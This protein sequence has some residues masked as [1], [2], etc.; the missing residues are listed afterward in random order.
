VALEKAHKGFVE[1]SHLPGPV[2]GPAA[3]VL[4]AHSG[5][6]SQGQ[7]RVSI[8]N[9][10]SF[11]GLPQDRYAHRHPYPNVRERWRRLAFAAGPESVEDGVQAGFEVL[12]G[13]TLAEFIG[14][15]DD[16]GRRHIA[17]RNGDEPFA[18]TNI[19]GARDFPEHRSEREH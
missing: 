19:G 7:A 4:L 13:L 1:A 8:V 10:P 15:L 17:D 18:N 16:L 5:A 2:G 3:D 14:S 6:P 11:A 12:G 9:Y